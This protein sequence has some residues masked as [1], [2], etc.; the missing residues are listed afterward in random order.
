MM[1]RTVSCALSFF[2]GREAVGS[3]ERCLACE[4]ALKSCSCSKSGV[5]VAEYCSMGLLRIAPRS[6]GVEGAC[7]PVGRKTRRA[8]DSVTLS[9]IRA[10]FE[11]RRAVRLAVCVPY[12]DNTS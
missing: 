4:A 6:R 8:E 5:G 2:P 3:V 7:E 9:L 10:G 12:R 11:P 1:G